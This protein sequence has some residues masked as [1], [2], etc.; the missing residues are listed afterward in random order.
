MIIINTGS[1][2][3]FEMLI[4]SVIYFKDKIKYDRLSEDKTRRGGDI[5]VTFKYDKCSL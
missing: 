3:I 4:N 5:V 1:K 2:R